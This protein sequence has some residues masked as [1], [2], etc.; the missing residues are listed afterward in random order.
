MLMTHALVGA[1]LSFF[2]PAGLCPACAGTPES[3]GAAEAAAAVVPPRHSAEHLFDPGAAAAGTLQ[4]S[5]LERGLLAA[6][7]RDILS[8]F[9]I[10]SKPAIIAVYFDANVKSNRG[11]ERRAVCATPACTYQV[12]AAGLA[13]PASS[14]GLS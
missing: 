14:C 6:D 8:I 1:E 10:S 9:S 11:T 12:L 4:R 13:R 2:G 5:A 7:A 3:A